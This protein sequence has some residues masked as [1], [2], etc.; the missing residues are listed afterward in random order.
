MTYLAGFPAISALRPISFLLRSLDVLK[1]F[2][3]LSTC[4]IRSELMPCF[5]GKGK[6]KG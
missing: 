6:C 3:L 1:V 5:K 4:F 2:V